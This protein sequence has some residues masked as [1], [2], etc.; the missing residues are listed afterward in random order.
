[1]TRRM[2]LSL[3]RCQ[4]RKERPDVLPGPSAV[5]RR[6]GARVARQRCPILRTDKCSLPDA[7]A[8]GK[9]SAGTCKAIN[10]TLHLQRLGGLLLAYLLDLFKGRSEHCPGSMRLT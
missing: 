8:R 10:A 3:C 9:L 7:I 5:Y 2:R 6:L 4:R 1:M